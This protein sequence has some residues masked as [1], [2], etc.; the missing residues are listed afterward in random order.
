MR[1]RDAIE[2]LSEIR[3]DLA[4][5]VMVEVD[6][7]RKQAARYRVQLRAAEDHVTHLRQLL[8]ERGAA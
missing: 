1:F 7:A 5:P 3:P 8:D 4:E 2:E 6:R